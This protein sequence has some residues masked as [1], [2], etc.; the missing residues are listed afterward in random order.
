M[1]TTVLFFFFAQAL[2]I[3]NTDVVTFDNGDRLTGEI[4]S[5]ER[6]RLRF[7]TDATGIISIE[8]D[9]VAFLKSDRNLQVE[10]AEGIRHLGHLSA[11]AVGKRIVVETGSGP[12]DLDLDNVILM[13]PIEERGLDRIDGDISA[14][15]NFA[16]AEEVAYT[17]LS[18]ELNYRTESRIM[19][20]DYDSQVTDTG[21]DDVKPSQDLSLDL[22]YNRLLPNRWLA[23]GMVSFERNDEQGLDLRSS[24]GVGGGRYLLQSNDASVLLSGGLLLSREERTEEPLLPDLDDDTVV[25]D[26]VE[27]FVELRWDWFRFDTPELDLTT[28]L[29]VIPNITESGEYRSELEVKLKW[30]IIEDFFWSLSLTETYDSKV[31]ETE[32]EKNDYSIITAIGYD[33]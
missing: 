11:T 31:L 23:G 17:N 10:T 24:V 18:V 21:E 30:E 7:K 13:A 9:D 29:Q 26:Y 28:T 8:W 15:L 1:I 4:K 27:A 12:V 5:L 19:T 6:G 33:F 3:E 20:L 2:A 14:G 16:K 22:E 25:E 32:G